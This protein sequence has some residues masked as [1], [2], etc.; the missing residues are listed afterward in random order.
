MPAVAGVTNYVTGMIITGAGATAAAVIAVTLTG[1]TGG[2]MTFIMDIPAGDKAAA[3]ILDI[4]FSVAIP[5]SAAN[6]AITLT[7][8]AFGAGNTN[9]AAVIYGFKI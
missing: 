4:E 8:P 3:P 5:A 6:T 7:A 9:A 2:T 1:V